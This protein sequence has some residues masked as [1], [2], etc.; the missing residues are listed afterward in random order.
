MKAKLLV[1]ILL[2][3]SSE[4]VLKPIQMQIP[5]TLLNMFKTLL[6]FQVQSDIFI[7]F[8]LND[9]MLYDRYFIT[10]CIM[11]KLDPIRATHFNMNN[12]PL[13]KYSDHIIF[14][15]SLELLE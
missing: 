15:D 11:K 10:M 2:V 4:S 7:G 9:S 5:T 6:E 1:I 12:I 8:T 14:T 13:N 3:A